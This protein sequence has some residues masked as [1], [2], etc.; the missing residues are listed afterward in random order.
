M[1]NP[2]EQSR[3]PS[4]HFE[5]TPEPT[6]LGGYAARHHYTLKISTVGIKKN[7]GISTHTLEQLHTVAAHLWLGGMDRQA[8]TTL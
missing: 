2:I 3:N 5:A 8:V 1:H 7:G 4:L 6:P